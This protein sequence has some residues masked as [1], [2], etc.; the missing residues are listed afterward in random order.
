MLRCTKCGSEDEFLVDEL[1]RRTIRIRSASDWDYTYLEEEEFIEIHAWADATC[2][3][4]QAT[5]DSEEA[6]S[7]YDDAHDEDVHPIPY[8]LVDASES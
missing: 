7:A 5:M 8:T 3:T 1:C 4:C 2:C 6:K